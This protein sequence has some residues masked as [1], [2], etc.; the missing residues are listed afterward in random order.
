MNR[1]TI[2]SFA[3]LASLAPAA[4]LAQQ[5]PVRIGVLND[6]SSV[7]ADYQG[8]GSIIAARLAAEDFGKAL[9]QPVEIVF[10]DHQNKTARTSPAPG[11]TPA[12]S[13]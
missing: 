3:L 11:S 6:L 7:Y 13:I 5:K 12:A 1:R 2:L 4:A 9:G 8:Q 10:A